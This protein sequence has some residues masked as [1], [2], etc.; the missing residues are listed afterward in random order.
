MATIKTQEDITLETIASVVLD[1]RNGKLRCEV[2]MSKINNIIKDYS[3]YY[4]TDKLTI[5]G[6]DHSKY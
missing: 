6:R 2:A 3:A 5:D 1:Y 4:C